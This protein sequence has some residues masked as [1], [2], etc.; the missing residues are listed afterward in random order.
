MKTDLMFLAG[1]FAV[2]WAV[3]F[4]YV[5]YV[6]R[7]QRRLEAEMEVLRRSGSGTV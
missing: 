4:G 3:L 2:A 6:N 5:V 7:L 1:A